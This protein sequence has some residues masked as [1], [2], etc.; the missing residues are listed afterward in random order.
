MDAFVGEI[1]TFGGSFAPSG[2]LPCDGRL[3]SISQYEVLYTLIGTTYGGDG[4]STFG[5]PDLQC[6]APMH[7]QQG[8]FPI[9]QK[10][11][12]E[13]VTLTLAEMP[14]HTHAASATNLGGTVDTPTNQLWASPVPDGNPPPPAP[15]VYSSTT[16]GTMNP[17]AVQAQG[18]NQPHDNMMPFLA[19]TF[20][21]CWQGLFPS[22]G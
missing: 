7:R 21:I 1:R 10:A 16:D 19:V 2:W 12:V 9:G 15:K 17:R 13:S 8:S 4:V 14:V 3:L 11:G 20:I 18:G 5:L 6:R 22:Q